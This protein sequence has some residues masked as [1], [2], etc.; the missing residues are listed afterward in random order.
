MR[1]P[2]LAGLEQL[3]TLEVLGDDPLGAE[4]LVDEA[5]VLLPGE[6]SV[7]VVAA[8]AGILVA[9]LAEHALPIDGVRHHHRG[10]GVVEGQGVAAG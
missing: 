4:Q 2:K 10:R 7:Q 8:G 3:P 1:A 9:A 6:R 5:L